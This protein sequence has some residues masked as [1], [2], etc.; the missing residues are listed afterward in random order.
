VDVMSGQ[1]HGRFFSHIMCYSFLT[2]YFY[3]AS[4]KALEGYCAFQQV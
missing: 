4:I 1:L 2:F 3:I